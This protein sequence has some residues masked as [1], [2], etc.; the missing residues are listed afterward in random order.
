[1]KKLVIADP[2]AQEYSTLEVAP[3]DAPQYIQPY[4]QII[5]ED[6]N[7]ITE[8]RICGL[9]VTTFWLSLALVFVLLLAVIGST[10]GGVLASRH[11]PQKATDR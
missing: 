10:I 3:H 5:H 4:S 11:S 8:R 2:K 9:R 6:R 1:M 7:I